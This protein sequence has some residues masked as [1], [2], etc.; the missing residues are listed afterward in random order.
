MRTRTRTQKL[1]WSKMVLNFF[2]NWRN[3]YFFE[4]INDTISYN[5]AVDI[6]RSSNSRALKAIDDTG[7]ILWTPL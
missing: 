2:H 7:Y 3:T 4:K 1:T 5:V 6:V